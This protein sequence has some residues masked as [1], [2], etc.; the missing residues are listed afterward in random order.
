MA[1]L[2]GWVAGRVV[3]RPQ[4][5]RKQSALGQEK[6]ELVPKPSSTV[7]GTVRPGTSYRKVEEN[8]KRYKLW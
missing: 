2:R 4:W 6:V 7:H 3:S 5:H 1:R 8:V